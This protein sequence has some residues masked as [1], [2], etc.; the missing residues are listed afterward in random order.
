MIEDT[1]FD[2]CVQ[3]FKKKTKKEKQQIVVSEIKKLI[4]VIEKMKSDAELKNEMLFNK[5]ILD[6]FDDEPEDEDFEEAMFVYVHSIQESLA[7]YFDF[8]LDVAYIDNEKEKL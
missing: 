8:I 1:N 3:N 5:E 6:D 7:E 2:L 4:A